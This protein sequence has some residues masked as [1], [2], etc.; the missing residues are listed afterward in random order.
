M[1]FTNLLWSFKNAAFVFDSLS[2]YWH[3]LS[4]R[5]EHLKEMAACVPDLKAVLELEVELVGL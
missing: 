2:N 4:R 5:T 1:P 3:A